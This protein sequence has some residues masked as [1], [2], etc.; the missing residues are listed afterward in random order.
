MFNTVLNTPLLIYPIY[1]LSPSALVA[2]ETLKTK[3][4]LSIATLKRTSVGW[5]TPQIF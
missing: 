5:E 2:P 3:A 1:K 4:I